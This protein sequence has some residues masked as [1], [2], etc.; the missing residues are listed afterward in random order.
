MFEFFIALFGG[1][2]Y[3]NKYF[4]E[5][6]KLKAFDFRQKEQLATLADIESKYSASLEL[7]QW[8]KDFISSGD[9]YDEICTWFAEDFRYALGRDWKEKLLIPTEFLP[10]T[11][12]YRKQDY[13]WVMPSA[14]VMWV[15]HL[16]L[17]KRGKIDHWAITSGFPIGG[18]SEKDMNVKFAECIEGQLM[19]AGVRGVRLA[20]E[21][22]YMY[23]TTRRTSSDLC[24]GDIKIEA[25]CNHPT[26]RLWDDYVQ[27]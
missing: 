8:A 2:F 3:T 27:K 15:Y 24:G 20:L 9:H 22:D 19:N 11:R 5:K 18:L 26:H 14:H 21:L 10:M 17:A 25:L 6:A 1:L 12:I 4:N 13:P 16:L 7:E 23:G